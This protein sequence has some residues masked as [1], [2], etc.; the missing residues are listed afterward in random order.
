MM[1][2]P[3]IFVVLAAA[4]IAC[5]GDGGST[6]VDGQ[7]GNHPPA[8]VIAGGGI[9]DG[10]VDGVVNLYVI[11]DATRAPVSGAAVTVGTVAGTTDATGLFVADGV[12]GPQSVVVKASGYRSEMWVGANGANMT[13]DVQVATP[14]TPPSATVAG[15]ILGFS[16]IIV[17]TGHARLA[18][19]TYSQTDNLGDA[20]NSIATPND[21]NVCVALAATATPCT[22]TVTTRVGNVSLIAL[23]FDRDLNGTPDDFS[24]DT[25]TL[26]GYA[27]LTNLTVA[28]GVAQT[29]KDLTIIPDAMIASETVD[30]GTPPS[31]LSTVEGIIGLD[32]PGGDVFQIGDFAMAGNLTLR[33]PS[34][35]S[36]NA[37]GYRLSSIAE[38]STAADA[39]QSVTLHRDLTSSTLSAGTWLALP[40]SVN[41]AHTMAAWTAVP[42][43]TVN[44]LE[45]DSG[46]T[47]LLNIT[48][49]DG[50]TSVM[51][52]D[53]ELLPSGTLT[54]KVSAIGA[55]GLD[56]TNFSLDADKAKL[57]EV[58]SQPAQVGN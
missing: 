42:G 18:A 36:V 29:G 33:V 11:D 56:V 34:L 35:A 52:P 20:A 1:S 5:G 46:T 21:T 39:A 26:I 24:D 2:F 4:L 3:T 16:S 41:I 47:A 49:F 13:V 12:T 44:G 51:I 22:F 10:A 23:I 7:T 28:S 58:A 57:S 17:P 54:A 14:A 31:G 15:Q 53:L 19:V 40:S 32:L 25:Q 30:F 38:N 9:G 27:A 8:R 48:T 55:P 43:A 45:Y 6:S 37:T 50:T